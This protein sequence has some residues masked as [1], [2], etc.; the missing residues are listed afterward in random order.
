MK[1]I[2]VP[3]DFSPCAENA[4]RF[5]IEA[6]R[7]LPG[8][9]TLLHA[10]DM[11]GTVYT[12]YAGLNKEFRQTMWGEDEKKL[13]TLQD[14]VELR[15]DV[16][17]ETRLMAGSLKDTIAFMLKADKYDLIIMGTLGASGLGE[18][19]WGSNTADVIGISSVPV[20]AIPKDYQWKKPEKFLLATGNF[21]KEPAVLDQIF[22]LAGLF[23]ARVDVAIFTDEHSDAVEFLEH[24]R[25]APWYKEMLIKHYGELDM[26]ATQLSGRHLERSLQE[27]IELEDV[28]VLVMISY[29][30]G[31]WNRLLHPSQTK[32]I[33]YHTKVPLLAVPAEVHAGTE[34]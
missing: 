9:I 24:A 5:A 11:P 18:K 20:L 7:F 28:D 34:A 23:M 6:S 14:T 25:S 27:Y 26:R 4:L 32:K 21:E 33:S 3:T 17:V 13:Q 2:L 19:L 12:D 8:K 22:E 15:Y 31:F 30:K 1:K 10:M 16:V 29:K